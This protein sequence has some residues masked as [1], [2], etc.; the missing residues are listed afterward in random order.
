LVSIATLYPLTYQY[1]MKKQ[2]LIRLVLFGGFWF[3]TI[4]FILGIGFAWIFISQMVYPGCPGTTPIF[5][6]PMPE[7]HWLDTGDGYSIRIWYYPTKNHASII[8]LGGTTGSL[9][10]QTF[11]IKFLLENGFGI[12]QVDT[13]ACASPSAPVTLGGNELYDAEA[14][15][16]FLL[17][18][19]QVDNGK[20]GAMGF[21][22]GGAT[23]IRLA[24]QQTEIQAVVR[25]G[26]FSNLGELL[27]PSPNNTIAIAFFQTIC[28]I[29]FHYQTGIDPLDV[30]PIE[31]LKMIAPRPVMLIYGEAEAKYGIEQY[32]AAKEQ[33]TLWIVPDSAHGMNYSFAPDEYEERLLTFF[34]QTLL[35]K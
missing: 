7:E 4:M 18:H 28:Q 5:G 10:T 27:N 31:D 2:R 19:D 9:G 26:G 23:A 32:Q 14:A 33:K 34:T 35:N 11:P 17:E 1:L 25:D 12:V 29:I 22:M 6:L 16:L 3:V 20:I 21:S 24:A 13:R 30:S 8:T 15:L